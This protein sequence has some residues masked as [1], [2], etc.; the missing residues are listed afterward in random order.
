MEKFVK[1]FLQKYFVLTIVKLTK[2][3]N[4]ITSLFLGLAAEV[5]PITYVI[6]ITHSLCK[7]DQFIIVDI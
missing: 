4:R 5:Y 2:R 7:L 6:I 1:H 3:Q